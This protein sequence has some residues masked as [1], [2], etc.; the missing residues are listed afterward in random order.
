MRLAPL[1]VVAVLA[2]CTDAPEFGGGVAATTV[3]TA[4]PA[5]VSTAAPATSSTSPSTQVSTTLPVVDPPDGYEL[6]WRDEFLDADL[7]RAKWNVEN[8][9]FGDG[10]DELQCYT[11]ENVSVDQQAGVLVLTG[12]PERVTCPNGDTRTVSSGKVSTEGLAAWRYGW[13]EVR[14]RV[15]EGQGLWPAIWL[16][17]ADLTYGRWPASGEIDLMEVRGQQPDT[18]RVNLHYLGP[19]G[20]RAQSP[21]DVEAAPG[22][23]FADFFHVFAVRWEPG[24]ITWFVDGVEVHEVSRWSS[25][26]GPAPAPFDQPFFLRLNLAIGGTFPGDPDDTTPWPADYLIDWVR[27]YQP[28]G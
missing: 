15:P 27:V 12:R 19:D 23:G 8:S 18:A 2:A 17:P 13:I 14:A 9:T 22:R 7:D 28:I 21:A 3:S 4:D 20:T 6:V 16:S 5:T 11:P 1:V 26:V 10:N 24:R 25:P